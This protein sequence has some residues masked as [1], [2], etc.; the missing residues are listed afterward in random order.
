MSYLEQYGLSQDLPT[1]L[2]GTLRYPTFSKIVDAFKKLGLL[3]LETLEESPKRWQDVTDVCLRRKGFEV[4]DEATRAA[5]ISSLIGGD[6]E[7]LAMVMDT[8]E[9][10]VL[11]L[12][13]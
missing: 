10:C 1:I 5:A 6:E 7:L 3:E 12:Q 2:R 13:P 11:S 8:L 4:V 9:Q